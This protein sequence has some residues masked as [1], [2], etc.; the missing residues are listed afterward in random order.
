MQNLSAMRSL[1]GIDKALGEAEAIEAIQ[2]IVNTPEEVNTEPSTEER[3]AA[4]L[5]FIAM[6][7]LPDKTI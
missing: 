7:S 3:T 4:A 2:T 1:Y 6:S 5:E